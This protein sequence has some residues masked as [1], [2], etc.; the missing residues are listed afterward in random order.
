[1]IVPWTLAADFA[2]LAGR[3]ACRERRVSA[4]FGRDVSSQERAA[5]IS[6]PRQAAEH[7][8][9]TFRPG[10]VIPMSAGGRHG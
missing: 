1:M 6:G 4:A 5:A 10:S 9:V 7:V 2:Q 3:R 8:R